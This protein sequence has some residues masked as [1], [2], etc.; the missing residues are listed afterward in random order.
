M[1]YMTTR[2]KNAMT[3]RWRILRDYNTNLCIAPTV[4]CE[5]EALKLHQPWSHKLF[6][7][8]FVYKPVLKSPTTKDDHAF[9]T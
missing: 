7:H 9:N 4:A 1:C 3:K 5:S 2:D 8:W 6:Q